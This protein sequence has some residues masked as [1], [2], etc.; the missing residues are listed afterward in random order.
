MI[1][2]VTKEAESLW[3]LAQQEEMLSWA[4]QR[5]R[6]ERKDRAGEK[7]F[8]DGTESPVEVCKSRE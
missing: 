2:L 6:G 7:S 4:K 3:E 1:T 5:Q 8:R